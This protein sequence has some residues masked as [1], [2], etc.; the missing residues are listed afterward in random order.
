MAASELILAGLSLSI[1]LL[2]R[3]VVTAYQLR[4]GGSLA[5]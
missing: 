1:R 4:I 5:A 3:R 2:G